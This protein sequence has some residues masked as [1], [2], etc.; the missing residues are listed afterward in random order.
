MSGSGVCSGV[1]IS[2]LVDGP[3]ALSVSSCSPSSCLAEVLMVYRQFQGEI[4][5]GL[6]VRP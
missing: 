6:S 4:P 2:G 3:G 5:T 1:S